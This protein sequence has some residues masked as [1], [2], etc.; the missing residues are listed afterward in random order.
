ML[1]TH[2]QYPFIQNFTHKRYPFSRINGTPLIPV[3]PCRE[4]PVLEPTP[5]GDNFPLVFTIRDWAVGK[6][7]FVGLLCPDK[8]SFLLVFL[9]L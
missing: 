3:P 2:K 1:S 5:L 6:E 9:L 8:V 4:K 7:F